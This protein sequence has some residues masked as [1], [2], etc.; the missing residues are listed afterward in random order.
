MEPCILGLELVIQ[1]QGLSRQD[2]SIPVRNKPEG[3][4]PG[5]GAEGRARLC[6]EA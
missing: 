5:H 6:G 4:D 3:W 2:L 1:P